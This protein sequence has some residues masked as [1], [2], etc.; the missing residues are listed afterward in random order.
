MRVDLRS[1]TI[2]KPSQEMKEFMLKAEV[3]DDVFGEDP[4]INALEN[5]I[6]KLFGTEGA[7]FTPTATMSNQI[8]L[9][10]LTNPL[11]EIICDRTSHIYNYEVGGYAFHS[12]CS[13]RYLEGDRGIIT[14][15]AIAKNI[16]AEDVHKTITKL[17][18]LENTANRG[19]GK[20]YPI[21]EIENIKKVCDN[22]QLN[23]HLDGSRLF[24]A[25]VE[26]KENA[27]VYGKLFDTI[28]LCFSKGLGCAFGSVLTGKNMHL[29]KA[30]RIRKVF[31][32]GMRQ[33][34]I[35]AAGCIYA[36]ENNID[37]LRQDHQ[38]A[39]YIEQQLMMCNFVSDIL[40]VETNII[41]FKLHDNI[42]DKSFIDHL[43]QND[44]HAFAIGDNWVRF[45]THLDISAD[46]AEHTRTVLG[47]M[48]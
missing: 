38:L 2:T 8:A 33:A 27:S 13:I 21:N 22:N 9:K 46:M 12:G 35:M 47:K 23:L 16:N 18:S 39:K 37:R 10:L 42:N 26:T 29:K 32:G 24:N 34:G 11:D 4:S 5:K 43:A 7:M 3:G 44:I 17:V 41:I 40:P 25:L 20:I 28:T 6:C 14:A 45:V 19:G 15:D 1:D 31:G 36:L 30:R 48:N